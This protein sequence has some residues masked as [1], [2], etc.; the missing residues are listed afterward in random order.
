MPS[1]RL[2]F[3]GS[4]TATRRSWTPGDLLLLAGGLITFLIMAFLSGPGT[5][6]GSG[7]AHP[8]PAAAAPAVP[9]SPAPGVPGDR[10]ASPGTGGAAAPDPAAPDP[11]APGPAGSASQP[12][13]GPALAPAAA[14]L[15]VVYPAAGFDVAV[16]PLT[17]SQA[18]IDSQT[19]VPPVSLDGFWVTTFG[20]P[21][22]GSANTTYIMGHSWDGRD[23]P[24]NRLSSGTAPG[25][26]FEL[27]TAT[28]TISYRVESIS[29]E[30]K[31]SLKDHPIWQ[32]VPNRLVLISCYTED[33]YGRNVIIV[34][35]PA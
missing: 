4:R 26:V 15:R 24:F 5:S 11:A 23:A 13:P 10:A 27:T 17:P 34:A 9:A 31:T 8:L 30:A 2:P 6:A 35:S 7:P 33:L 12:E 19:I 16:H 20:A 29:T 18:D 1:H 25:D 22:A 32:V 21:G 28:G 3:R 14:P